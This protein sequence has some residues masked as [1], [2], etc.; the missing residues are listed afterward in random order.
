MEPHLH[1]LLESI[2]RHSGVEYLLSI[3]LLYPQ[4]AKLISIAESKKLIEYGDTAELMLTEAGKIALA[5]RDLPRPKKDWIIPLV[6]MKISQLE[7]FEVYFPPKRAIRDLL[8]S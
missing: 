4:I 2:R 1:D 6:E 3:G 7:P 8:G 5:E